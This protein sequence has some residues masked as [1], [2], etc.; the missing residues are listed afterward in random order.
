MIGFRDLL[1]TSARPVGTFVKLPAVESVEL[2]ALGGFDFIVLDLEHSPMS[3]ETASALVAV[4][5]GRGLHA[6]V[7]V[8]DHAPIWIQRCLDIGVAG[9]VVPHVDNVAQARV[10]GRAARFEPRGTRGTVIPGKGDRT[11]ERLFPCHATQKQYD[12]K[13]DKRRYIGQG[14]PGSIS[15]WLYLLIARRRDACVISGHE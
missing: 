13:R 11:S 15:H 1:A 10:V 6:F 7:R 9:V 8:P 4:A 5:R 14:R 12:R 2:M 3:L